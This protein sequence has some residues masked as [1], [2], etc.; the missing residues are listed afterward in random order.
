MSEIDLDGNQAI[1]IDEFIA[2]LS[3][4][5]QIK[6]KNPLTKTTVVRIKHARK[7]QP[8]DFYNCFKNLPSS[9]QPSLTQENLE[10]KYSNT[11]SHG[12]YPEFDSQTLAYKDL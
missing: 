8:L 11:P 3:I 1:D 7:L 6:F 4:A 9:F 5:D 2:F 12:L 10:K